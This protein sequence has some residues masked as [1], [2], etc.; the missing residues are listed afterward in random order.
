MPRMCE[1]E[2]VREGTRVMMCSR[3]L[4]VLILIQVNKKQLKCIYL[5][6]ESLPA[7]APASPAS[8]RA[9]MLMSRVRDDGCLTAK[10][11]DPVS[12]SFTFL[13]ITFDPRSINQ[14]GSLY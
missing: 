14:I 10:S 6:F 12:L 5:P 13:P 1:G 4:G 9:S 7:H 11:P 8:W 2:G 3:A